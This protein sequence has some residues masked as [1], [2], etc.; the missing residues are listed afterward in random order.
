MRRLRARRRNG[1][2]QFTIDVRPQEK[3][4]ATKFAGLAEGTT[5]KA[6]IAAAIGRLLRLGLIALLEKG[7]IDAEAE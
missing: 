5:D 1:I 3:V 7:M 2:E 6:A 4:L